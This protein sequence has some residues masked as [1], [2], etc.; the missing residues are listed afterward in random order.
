MKPILTLGL[1]VALSWGVTA[2][3]TENK[4]IGVPLQAKVNAVRK[5][6]AFSALNPLATRSQLGLV[7]RAN[8]VDQ[9]LAIVARM[10]AVQRAAA[11]KGYGVQ[12]VGPTAQLSDETR[13]IH[14]K[15]GGALVDTTYA[16]LGVDR[17]GK[18]HVLL[19]YYSRWYADAP[20]LTKVVCRKTPGR[21]TLIGTD[22]LPLYD[23]ELER[24][25]FQLMGPTARAVLQQLQLTP[26]KI[27]DSLREAL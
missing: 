24:T 23:S 12:V 27:A 19:H 22:K 9:A 14:V 6:W 13:L 3:A 4:R 8:T 11:A 17:D 21:P 1:A 26:K 2:Q 18:P 7:E 20:D 15:G 25:R 16:A 10:P 5:W